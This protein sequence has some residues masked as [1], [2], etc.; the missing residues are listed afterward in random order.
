M[1]F[2]FVVANGSY[3][4]ECFV[5]LVSAEQGSDCSVLVWNAIQ[6]NIAS[7]IQAIA[8]LNKQQHLCQR[9]LL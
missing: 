4:P 6:G 1:H 9:I 8:A 7:R 2:Y 5:C 3:D